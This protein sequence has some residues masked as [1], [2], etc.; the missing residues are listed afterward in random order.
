MTYEEK[1]ELRLQISQLL[2]DAGINQESI[3]EMV[4]E[5]INKKV[6]KAIDQVA[7]N[8]VKNWL[9]HKNFDYYF[10]SYLSSIIREE[11]K[12]RVINVILKDTGIANG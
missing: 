11:L 6:D 12:D 7:I 9:E 4:A 3:K 10:R 2:A 8:V 1:R 5:A